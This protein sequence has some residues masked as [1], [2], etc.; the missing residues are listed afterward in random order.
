L[1]DVVPGITPNL[2]RCGFF[3]EK[4]GKKSLPPGKE[5]YVISTAVLYHY[6]SQPS[7]RP[8]H[9]AGEELPDIYRRGASKQSTSQQ[10]ERGC[11]PSSLVW[12]VVLAMIGTKFEHAIS[13]SSAALHP[14]R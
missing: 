9:P 5:G 8:L 14:S 4:E 13:S 12:Q 11:N 6:M 7:S 2:Y 1:Q 10:T 3:E